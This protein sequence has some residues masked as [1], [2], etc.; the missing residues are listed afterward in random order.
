V[1]SGARPLGARS[2]SGTLALLGLVLVL[3]PPR[4][5][6]AVEQP[7]VLRLQA[8]QLA[9]AGRCAEAVPL[10][11]RV[12][13][14]APDDA[15]AADDLGQ[16]QLRLQRWEAAVASFETARRLAP[17]T[18]DVDLHLAAA[19]F[20]AGDLDGAESALADARKRSPESAQVD[21]YQG[22]ILL[23][24]GTAPDAAATALERA[25]QRD[26]VG[27]EPVASYYEGIA[28]LRAEQRRQ[29]RAALERVEK[30]APGT[31]WAA[32]AARALESGAGT[33][34]L[35][36]RRDL[37]APQQAERPLGS[38]AGLHRRG[39]WVVASAGVE[40]DSNVAL[41]GDAVHLPQEIS[42]KKDVR[43]VW[44]AQVGNE[45][46]H[47]SNWTFGAIG[48][49]YGSAQADLTD[50][51]TEYPSL[52]LWGD[53]RIGEATTAR[54]QYDF[55]YAWVGYDPYL[56]ENAVTPA[57]FHDWGRYGTTR[58]FARL[59]WDD[60]RYH[61]T[62]VPA[63]TGVPYSPCPGGL[64]VCGP[65]GL[66]ER[67]ARE[68]DG[69]W[70]VVGFDHTFAVDPLSTEFTFGYHFHDYNSEGKEFSFIGHEIQIGSH[71]LLPWQFSLDVRG[72]YMLQDYAHPSTYPDPKHVYSGLEYRL[73]SSDKTEQLWELDTILSRPITHWMIGSVRFAYQNDDSNVRVFD[74]DRFIVG[75]YLTFTVPD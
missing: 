29:A 75:G 74:Y 40:W 33:R 66:N 44:T 16:C 19:R 67:H 39:P 58:L 73:P 47:D 4:A 14:L 34:G 57:V 5:A 25:R 22:L 6:R 26:P 1:R 18:P 50:F 61:S 8:E 70:T 45:F 7:E 72:T 54:L 3:A 23:E 37:E 21:L 68:R 48:A 36:D 52:T 46:Y 63:G 51:D 31:A 53:R 28:L 59:S 38:M 64:S 20:H 11:E 71:T 27:L 17:D 43:A 13:V 15:R 32:A 62:N 12:R 55:S 42:G 2:A 41:R 65:P 35:R 24:R 60:F 10:L 69:F 9:G 49:Y 30:E 56:M